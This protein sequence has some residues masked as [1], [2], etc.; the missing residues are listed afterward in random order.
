MFLLF[1]PYT[2]RQWSMTDIRLVNKVAD[3]LLEANE[4]LEPS[5]VVGA[6]R[7]VFRPGMGAQPL[8]LHAR[9]RLHARPAAREAVADFP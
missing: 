5:E 6:I 9:R 1:D 4:N 7:N 2:N 3:A 8:M